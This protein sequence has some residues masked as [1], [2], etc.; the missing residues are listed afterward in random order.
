MR[1]FDPSKPANGFVVDDGENLSTESLAKTL[2]TLGINV[3]TNSTSRK[4][5]SSAVERLTHSETMSENLFQSFGKKHNPK[6]RI[7]KK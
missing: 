3:R 1:V 2:L 5:F 6:A 4:H 7:L